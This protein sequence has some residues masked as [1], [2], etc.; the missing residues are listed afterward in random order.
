MTLETSIKQFK[1]FVVVGGA[2]GRAGSLDGIHGIGGL[3]PHP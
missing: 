3:L 2:D 1:F